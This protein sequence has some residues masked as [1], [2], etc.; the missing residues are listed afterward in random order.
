MNKK[1]LQ[2]IDEM[3]VKVILDNGGGA[4]LI[5]QDL[6]QHCYN[7]MSQLADDIIA[8]CE[9]GVE[10]VEQWGGNE[11]CICDDQDID[12]YGQCNNCGG[13]EL[14]DPSDD[15]L[16]NGGYYIL[17]DSTDLMP[18]SENDCWG[19]NGRCLRAELL[20]K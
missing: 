7:N 5:V 11:L 17:Y 20:K 14:L 16:R 3:D 6:Y 12:E 9:D 13:Y 15:E 18:L 2:K 1:E 8:L 19:G 10:S 4:T